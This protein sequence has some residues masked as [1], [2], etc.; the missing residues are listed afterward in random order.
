MCGSWYLG[1]LIYSS[2]LCIMTFNSV[3]S[4]FYF[5]LEDL[6]IAESGTVKSPIT[7]LELIYISKSNISLITFL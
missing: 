2:L 4:V 6:S 1:G 5:C 3:I 7:G